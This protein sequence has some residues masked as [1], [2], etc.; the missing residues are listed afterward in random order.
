V[1][2]IAYARGLPRE[3]QIFI[4][5]ECG[6]GGVAVIVAAVATASGR[7]RRANN[8]T[9]DATGTCAQAAKQGLVE[10]NFVN[11]ASRASVSA[12][13]GAHTNQEDTDTST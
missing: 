1:L 6:G 7:Q 10:Q 8:P 9:Y 5:W 11:N 4:P 2:A 3:R 12:L 13:H